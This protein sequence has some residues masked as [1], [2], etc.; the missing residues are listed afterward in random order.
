[1]NWMPSQLWSWLYQKNIVD[2]GHMTNLA[3]EF[4]IHLLEKTT[5]KRLDLIHLNHS[6]STGTQKFLWQLEDGQQIESVYIPEGSRRTV[7]VS[8]QVGC[9]MG[10]TFCATGR[11][12]LIRN[13]SEY[14]ILEQVL[15]IWDRINE[16][17]TNIVVMG[18]GEPFQNYE[19]VIKSLTIL[20]H[21][22]G[23]AMGARKITISTCG[24]VPR[25]LQFAKE[26]QPFKLA[27]SLNAT[28]DAVRSRIMPINRKYPLKE[29]MKAAKY[30]SHHTRK[31]IT[32]EYV[33]IK[34]VND[35]SEDAGRLLKLLQD[36][37]CKINL[38]AYNATSGKYARPD[39]AVIKRFAKQIESICAPVILRLSK[40][41][42]I[43]GA[44][45][46]LLV[47]KVNV[48]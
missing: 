10:C 32:F 19:N 13:L 41:D 16:K 21:V 36:L 39:E 31:R 4:R 43:N 30:Y 8:T 20:N 45:G 28:T 47:E 48:F 23:A 2:F 24:I 26:R 35:T 15:S 25:I 38:I 14:E 18:M 46:Q 37:P 1:M 9:A 44:C 5:A 7:C 11:M 3:K 42:D 34:D 12:G 22:D 6:E 33:L 29:L 27:I 17:P 40:G